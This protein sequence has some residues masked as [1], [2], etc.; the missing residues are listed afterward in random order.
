M[1][2]PLGGLGQR[3]LQLEA[4]LTLRGEGWSCMRPLLLAPLLLVAA[5]APEDERR[6]MATSFDRLRVDG[7]FE[8]E[9]VSGT[10]AAVATGSRAAL[11]QV[12]VRVDSGVMVVSSGVPSWDA[13]KGGNIATAKVRISVPSLRAVTANGSARVHVGA[14]RGARVDLSLN[15]S[16]SLDIA[17]VGADDLSVSLSGTGTMTIAG[18]A[19]R[20]RLRGYGTG[21][22][23]AAGVTADEVTVINESAG[24]I[25]IAARTTAR[26][27]ALGSGAIEI[28]GTPECHVAGSGPVTCAGS[29]KSN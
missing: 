14:M 25:R 3:A 1:L 15:G 8:V 27:T 6:F 22:I 10:P 17:S 9:V 4:C 7:P 24:P 5:A 2:G 29:A 20:A 18:R 21:S 23:D 26:A 13:R 12:Q 11:D 28:G 16:G 19:R